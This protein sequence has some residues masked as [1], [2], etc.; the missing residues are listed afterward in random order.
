M[1]LQKTV[2]LPANTVETRLIRVRFPPG[3]KTPLHT[4]EGPGPRYV[5]QGRLRVEDAG[6][7]H[8][9]GAGDVFWETGS[10]MTVENIG[11]S[12]A[13]LVIFELAAA[14]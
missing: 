1:L 4:H 14:K 11:G 5:L 8:D 7:R 2:T 6:E 13:E 3:Y 9:Y 10:A 12:D